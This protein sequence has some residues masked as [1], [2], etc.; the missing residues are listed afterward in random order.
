LSQIIFLF[1]IIYYF[2]QRRFLLIKCA[3]LMQFLKYLVSRKN[4]TNKYNIL[5]RIILKVL[6][7]P[8]KD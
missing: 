5:K 2:S 7:G 4:Q 8:D 6:V 1:V 3:K